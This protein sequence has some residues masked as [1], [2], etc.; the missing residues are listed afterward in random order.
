M[1]EDASAGADGG[2]SP[3]ETPY[4]AAAESAGDSVDQVAILK[5]CSDFFS[6]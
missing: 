6:S 3:V 2:F 5:K 1:R 4:G